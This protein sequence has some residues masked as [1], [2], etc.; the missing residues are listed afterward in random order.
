MRRCAFI[1]E[2][3]V[4]T[5]WP[6]RPARRAREDAIIAIVD[7]GGRIL[8]VRMEQ[9]VLDNIPDM[10]TRVFAIDGAVAKA[11]T[12][13]FF[14]NNQ[15]P[16]T[17]RTIR[18]LSQSTITRAR[19]RIESDGARSARCLRRIRSSMPTRS[20]AR[21]ARASSRRSASAAIF[22]RTSPHTPPVDLFNIELQSRD[23]LTHAGRWTA[24][25]ARRDDIALPNRFNVPDAFLRA[26]VDIPAP[27][28]YGVQSGLVPHAI[29]RGIAT[30]PGG[31][32]LYKNRSADSR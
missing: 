18:S 22:R 3:E 21:S 31:I 10:L 1:T 25:R 14:A 27:E 30:L 2:A 32:P 7:R 16:L 19:G 4:E 5:C 9:G 20:R 28:S 13:A 24:S 11:R 6:A 17:S 15:A 29:G 12:A 26:R 8:G 23:G